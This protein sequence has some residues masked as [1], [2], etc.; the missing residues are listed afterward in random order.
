MAHDDFAFEP[1]KGLP[2]P[3]PKGEEIL[4][5]GRPDALAL[6]RDSLLL[7]WVIGY[8]VVLAVWRALVTSADATL[9]MALLS[10]LPFVGL[11]VIVVGLL[12]GF[13]WAQARATVYTVTTA[14]IAMRIGAA[15]SITLNLPYNWIGKA[16]LSLKKDGTGTL[17]LS[18]MGETRI[19]YLVCWPHVRPWHLARTQPAFRCIPDARRIAELVSE[20]AEARLTQPQVTR[21][22]ANHPLGAPQGATHAA[23]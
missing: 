6:A 7:Y 20:A 17:A 12:Y 10:A 9:G 3:L 15:L 19:S 11:G 13:A 22:P 1:V 16:D 23:E 14:R 18:T 8:F 5:Q 2:G 4:W 21:S